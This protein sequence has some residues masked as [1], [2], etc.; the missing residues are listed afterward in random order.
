MKTKKILNEYYGIN[1]E[2]DISMTILAE[3]IFEAVL[4][5]R[6]LIEKDGSYKDDLRYIEDKKTKQKVEV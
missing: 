3:N 6:A 4:K 1:K 2:N 5:A